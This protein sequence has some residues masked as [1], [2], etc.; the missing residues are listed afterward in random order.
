[1]FVPLKVSSTFKSQDHTSGP[2]KSFL[3]ASTG[4]EPVASAFAL[5]CSNSLVVKTHAVKAGQ[6]I[7]LNKLDCLQCMVLHTA[8]RALQRK[9]R[10]H[11]FESR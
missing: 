9:R 5:Q 7:E 4:F 10:G 11:G 3:G 6:F 1:M 8:G 2:K